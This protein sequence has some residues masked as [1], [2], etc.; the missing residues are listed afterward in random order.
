MRSRKR[1][2]DDR[3]VVE[4]FAKEP[5]LLAIT[6]ALAAGRPE[7]RRRRAV[8]LGVAA[9][10]TVAALALFGPWSGKAGVVDEALAAVGTRPVVH[11]IV[12]SE[13]PGVERVDIESG[14]SRRVTVTAEVWSDGAEDRLR[15]LIRHDGTVV[16][17]V[18]G[19]VAARVLPG[20]TDS[21]A[22]IFATGYRDALAA[23]GASVIKRGMFRGRDAIWLEIVIDGRRQE[24]VIDADAYSP[25]AVRE[26]A[27]ED[28]MLWDVELVESVERRSQDFETEP[29]TPFGEGGS[30]VG[31]ERIELAAAQQRV[32][33]V[34]LWAGS[35][36][37]GLPYTAAV[38]QT[39]SRQ[40][41]ARR[42][43]GLL[44][45]YGTGGSAIEIAQAATPEP[46][47][48]FI[49]RQFTFHLNPVPVDE[50]ELGR[51]NAYWIGQI[52]RNGTYVRI[53]GDERAAVVQAARQLAP[54]P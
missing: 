14:T 11:T 2:Y 1:V 30:V 15:A 42:G 48:G 44:V 5:E 12:S 20:L 38:A 51:S 54:V 23:G 50:I 29:Q 41:D 36:I 31:S 34:P 22:Q 32:G 43:T 49:R 9:V 3:E 45:R 33:F 13:L 52:R 28:G 53:S 4:L 26:A 46:A 18:S 40:G 39:L 37:G 17:D 35:A 24:V 16:A 10:A 21:G 27:A 19:E 8:P 7:P 47:Y 25:I 6:D